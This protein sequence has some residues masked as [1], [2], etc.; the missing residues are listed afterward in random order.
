M[1]ELCILLCAHDSGAGRLELVIVDRAPSLVSLLKL[2]RSQMLPLQL[3]L[4]QLL[5]QYTRCRACSW[6]YAR[7]KNALFM[8]V[9]EPR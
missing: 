9:Y 7:Y 1:K 4:H 8:Q 2:S 6:E 3:P 5:H